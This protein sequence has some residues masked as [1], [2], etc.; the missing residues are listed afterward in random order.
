MQTLRQL[1][2][3]QQVLEGTSIPAGG[4]ISKVEMAA[5][6]GRPCRIAERLPGINVAESILEP[7]SDIS[8]SLRG[9]VRAHQE[10]Q[11]VSV[12]QQRELVRA[13]NNID[14]ICWSWRTYSVVERRSREP[15]HPE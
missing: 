6:G 2:G 3:V 15:T 7:L 5:T 1:S 12:E 8:T 9:L 13:T 14:R 4:T 10:R 11:E